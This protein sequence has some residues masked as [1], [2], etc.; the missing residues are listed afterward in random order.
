MELHIET[1]GETTEDFGSF[2][3]IPRAMPSS[4]KVNEMY[5]LA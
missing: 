3:K 1:V 4:I 2:W 5:H